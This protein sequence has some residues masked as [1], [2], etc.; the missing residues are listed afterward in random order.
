MS[1]CC[2]SAS[3]S[4]SRFASGIA[5]SVTANRLAPVSPASEVGLW[6]AG[7]AR[8]HGLHQQHDHEPRG[9]EQRIRRLTMDAVTPGGQD[10]Q[11]PEAA[12]G[13]AAREHDQQH[14]DGVDAELEKRQPF[15]RRPAFLQPAGWTPTPNANQAAQI[16]M[17]IP[18]SS[19][20]TLRRGASKKNT[21]SSAIGTIS[22][23][24]FSSR[25]R[26]GRSAPGAR[27]GRTAS[28]GVSSTGIGPKFRRLGRPQP[29]AVA[30]GGVGVDYAALSTS[31]PGP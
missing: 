12:R 3:L 11:H 14:R 5:S 26:H 15:G 1:R 8:D 23:N 10:Q 19:A 24:R 17:N 4:R 22:R 2:T 16:P 30:R 27:A 7:D 31:R 20:P 18:G 25:T 6:R 29:P 9:R 21:I 28:A 13:A